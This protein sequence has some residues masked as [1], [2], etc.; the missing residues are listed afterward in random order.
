MGGSD[1]Y[2]TPVYAVRDLYKRRV[3][4]G[5][6]LYKTGVFGVEDLYKTDGGFNL[7]GWGSLLLTAW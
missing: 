4:A 5:V 1:L 6:G 2:K 3:L 7:V